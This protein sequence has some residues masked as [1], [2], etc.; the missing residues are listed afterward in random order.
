MQPN[1]ALAPPPTATSA[2]PSPQL[3][4]VAAYGLVFSLTIAST[5]PYSSDLHKRITLQ[6]ISMAGPQSTNTTSLIRENPIAAPAGNWLE[7]VI[8]EI[9]AQ[10][11][12]EAWAKVPPIRAA[13]IDKQVYRT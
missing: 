3:P 6:P 13:D 9:H 12:E 2:V 8:D 10:I 7:A 4:R 1:L 11:P 5:A